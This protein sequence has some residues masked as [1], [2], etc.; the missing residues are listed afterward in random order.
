MLSIRNQMEQRKEYLFLIAGQ[1]EKAL[2]K[3]PQGTLRIS[4]SNGRVQY[5]YREQSSDRRGKYIPRKKI[6]KA[7]S[8]AQKD[9]NKKLLSSIEK[10]MEVIDNYLSLIEEYRP[11][12]VYTSLTKQRQKLVTPY[13]E[14]DEVFLRRWESVE[15]QGKAISDDFDGYLTDKGERVR[16]KSELIIANLLAKAGVPY[17]YEYP[18]NLKGLGIVHPD[19]LAL[20]LRLRKEIYWEHR[21]MMDDPDYVQKA[22]RKENIYQLN[23]IYPGD[24]LILTSETR[25]NPLNVRQINQ[26]ITHYF[27]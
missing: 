19:F 11:E 3:A 10:E 18:V 14:T 4:C 23:G 9:Y 5:Y 22:V 20:N 8:L 13:F 12:D 21:G 27:L 26:I 15:Y 2:R 24:T 17:R 25:T 7:Q 6:G 1:I 16:S